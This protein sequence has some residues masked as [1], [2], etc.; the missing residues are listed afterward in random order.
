M[1]HCTNPDCS[2]AQ[3]THTADPAAGARPTSA[4]GGW[5]S[6]V[7]DDAGN[8]VIS[9]NSFSFTAGFNHLKVLHCTNPDCSGAQTTRSPDTASGSQYTSIALDAAGN[10]VISYYDAFSG[11]LKVLHCTNPDCSGA[12]TTRSPD[13]GG[14]VG[15]YTS[16]ALDAAGNPVISYYDAT[17]G[18]LKVLHCTNPDCSGAQTTRS[19]DTGGDVGSYTSIALDAAGNP[20]ISYRDVG[21][22]E[23]KVLHCTNPDCSGAQTTHTAD[24][25]GDVGLY[26]SVVLD[27]AGNP[28]ISYYDAS[29]GDLKVV[30][31]YDPGGCGVTPPRCFGEWATIV[32]MP[33]GEATIGTSGPDVIVGTSG[34]DDLRGRGGDDLICGRG[35]PDDIVGNSGDDR[36]KGGGGEDTLRGGKGNDTIIGGPGLDQIWGNSGADLIRGNKGDDAIV[37]GPGADVVSGGAGNDEIFGKKGHDTLRG[38]KNSDV[39]RGGT[40]RDQLNGG[41]GEDVCIGGPGTDTKSSCEN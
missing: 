41:T 37:G 40:G 2:G 9:Y 21:N 19:P 28:V 16:I 4:T 10:P 27:A 23:L 39:L 36:I 3:T 5:L 12:Q 31:C 1:L 24:P 18:D 6:M 17:N 13:T 15:S 38:N 34:H 35:G 29:D 26:T 20:V 11:D 32:A 22:K 7:L 33:G 14:D 8:P 25:A 30:H